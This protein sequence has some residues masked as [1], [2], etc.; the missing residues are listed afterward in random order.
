MTSKAKPLTWDAQWAAVASGGRSSLGV[1][2]PQGC[3]PWLGGI[4]GLA[5]GTASTKGG[6][7][8]VFDAPRL[9]VAPLYMTGGA[10]STDCPGKIGNFPTV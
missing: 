5:R 10:W 4:E 8:A 1:F 3:E 9:P 7:S 2:T 6:R